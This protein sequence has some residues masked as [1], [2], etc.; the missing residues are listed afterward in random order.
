MP[1]VMSL[2]SHEARTEISRLTS[3]LRA[4]TSR[5][6]CLLGCLLFIRRVMMP[7][8]LLTLGVIHLFEV[9]P[10]VANF[11]SKYLHE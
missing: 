7:V 10:A 11:F 2:V 4:L 9:I 6:P 3:E 1:V 8:H 5:P